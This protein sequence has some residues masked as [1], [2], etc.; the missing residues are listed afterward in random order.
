[1]KP[2]PKL[3]N[4][5]AGKM[6]KHRMHIQKILF[7]LFF[8]RETRAKVTLYIG[9]AEKKC[10]SHEKSILDEIRN[11]IIFNVMVLIKRKQI[12]QH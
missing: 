3:A 12:V 11:T 9:H 8:S 2:S 4:E 1:M 10:F 5:I 6:L 7:S